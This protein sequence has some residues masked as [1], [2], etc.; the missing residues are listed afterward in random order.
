MPA[1]L[2]VKSMNTPTAYSGIRAWVLAAGGD[3]QRGRDEP[4]TTMPVRER[5]PVAAEAELAREE[6]VLAEDRGQ[7]RE[8][9]EARVRGQ[10]QEQR[11]ERLEQVEQDRPSPNTARPPGR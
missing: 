3:D 1:W 2:I 6:A 5:E 4:S 9:G 11:R 8:R 10:E 7:A